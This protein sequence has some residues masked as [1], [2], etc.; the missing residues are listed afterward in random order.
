MTLEAVG[1]TPGGAATAQGQRVVVRFD[2]RVLQV[3]TETDDYHFHVALLDRFDLEPLGPASS[4][5]VRAARRGIAVPVQF[6][7]RQLAELQSITHAVRA[8]AAAY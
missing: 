8:A 3:F 2:G 4:L 7:G 1:G 5:T 6:S